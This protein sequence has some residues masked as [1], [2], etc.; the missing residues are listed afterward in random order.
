[1]TKQQEILK[2]KALAA[3]LGPDSYLAPWIADCIPA[4]EHALKMDT[5][6]TAEHT[7]SVCD[8]R[9]QAEKEL[10]QAIDQAERIEHEADCKIQDMKRD[11][12]SLLTRIIRDA[13][14]HIEWCK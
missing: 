2:L 5:I 8:I 3:E 13:S 1:M 6:P 14:K 9:R 12:E 11:M 4:L 10:A 7:L